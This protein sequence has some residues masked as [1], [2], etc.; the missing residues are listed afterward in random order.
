MIQPFLANWVTIVRLAVVQ[1][2]IASVT[3]IPISTIPRLMVEELSLLALLPAGLIG[4][5]YAVQATRVRFGHGSDRSPRRTP[6]ILAGLALL[7]V[8]G[9][10]CAFATR[11]MVTDPVAGYIAA[12]LAYSGVGIGVGAAG[13]T[14]FALVSTTVAPERRAPAATTIFLTMILGLVITSK[15]AGSA[16][17]P[18]SYQTLIAVSSTVSL[19]AF[20]LGT[21]A[22]LG[23]ER[24]RHEEAPPAPSRFREA[25]ADVWRDP[26]VRGFTV[27]VFLSMFAY[28]MQE[29]VMEPFSAAVFG[30]EPGASTRLSGDHHAGVFAG[31]ILMAVV[32]RLA[33]GRPAAL[34]GATVTG[35]LASAVALA[36]LAAAAL[37]A[38]DWPLRPTILV[39]G[40]ANGLFAGGAI[41]AMFSLA[42]DGEGGR[43]GTRV[44][45][46]GT[47]QAL[48]FGLGMVAGAGLLD[49][50]RALAADSYAFASVFLVE[51]ALFTIASLVAMRVLQIFPKDMTFSALRG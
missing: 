31:L 41:A 8:S 51:G 37:T 38:P 25:L 26:R 43:E 39:Y 12:L 22:M 5:H 2:A 42:G 44:G 23:V 14:L 19:A 11:L 4:A 33:R 32:G 21:L 20:T 10:G 27:F 50:T 6:W 7:S 36:G 1:A 29:L 34:V 40:L 35:C 28:N 47:A 3:V 16:M 48:G 18:F 46:W 30:L 45:M 9:V 49:A 15:L 24:P 17:I 13:T